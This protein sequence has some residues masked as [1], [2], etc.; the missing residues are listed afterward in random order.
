MKRYIW[1]PLA[2]FCVGIA[3]YIYYGITMNAWTEN[4]SNILGYAAI[5]LAL[6]WALKKKEELADDRNDNYTRSYKN[7]NKAESSRNEQKAEGSSRN[8]QNTASRK[9]D[10]KTRSCGKGR[11]IMEI[12]ESIEKYVMMK[13]Q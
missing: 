7:D 3:F 2:F 1:T 4:L 13:K 12:V 6:S 5:L 11:E 8:E 10:V 9:N